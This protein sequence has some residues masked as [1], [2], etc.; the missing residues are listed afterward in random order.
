MSP[1]SR[2]TRPALAAAAGALLTAA[3]VAPAAADAGRDGASDP[4]P[5]S[6]P[7]PDAG[8][9]APGAARTAPDAGTQNTAHPS[10]D[11]PAGTR[12][13]GP[14]SNDQRFYRGRVTA[15]GGLALHDRPDRGSRVIRVVR[16]G[17][18][19]WIHCKTAGRN[20]SGN[21]LWYLLAD[22]TWAWVSARFVDNV[23][24]AP[25]WC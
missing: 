8:D 6:G 22:G 12:P 23:G 3:A 18:T 1:R 4:V 10:G 24:P 11:G 16:Q 13:N 5:V 19:V 2:L 7:G 17:E 20:V 9:T 15:R 14:A 25:R 21:H